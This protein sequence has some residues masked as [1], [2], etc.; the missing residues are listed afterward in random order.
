MNKLSAILILFVGLTTGSAHAET[1]SSRVIASVNAKT[2]SVDNLLDYAKINPLFSG[3]LGTP[4]GLV[5]VLN[6]MI[7]VRLLNL[8]GEMQKI[9]RE[10]KS[11]DGAYAIVVKSNLMEKCEPLDEAGS[12]AF[13]E[14]HP[15]AFSSPAYARVN[16]IYLKNSDLLDGLT[17]SEFMQAQAKALRSNEVNFE[18]IVSKVRPKIPAD[19]PLGDIGFMPLVE[20]H[21][22]VEKLSQ[23]GIGD[24]IEPFERNGYIYLFQVTDRREP[25]VANWKDAQKIAQEVAYRECNREHFYTLRKLM[26]SHFPVVIYE[27]NIRNL[28]RN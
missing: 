11:S 15:E 12:K 9:S 5:R 19:I 26:E 4:D 14:A 16:K 20:K 2:I 23:A 8:E 24:V 10:A 25:V 6:D 21:E 7:N 17:A 1:D 18:D 27:D 22:L 13:F 3:E 28:T